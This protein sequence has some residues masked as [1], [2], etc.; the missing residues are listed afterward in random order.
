MSSNADIFVQGAT[1]RP[2]GSKPTEAYAAK[3]TTLTRDGLT[4]DSDREIRAGQAFLVILWGEGS[5]SVL[6]RRVEVTEVTTPVA[7]SW[8]AVTKFLV[9]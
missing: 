5:Q 6:M 3:I 1:I 8:L 2:I 4:I 9:R 7:G